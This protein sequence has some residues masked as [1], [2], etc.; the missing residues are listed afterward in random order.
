MREPRAG[1][2]AEDQRGVPR[3][4]GPAFD[5]GAFEYQY[6]PFF[7]AVPSL[8]AT[9]VSL[10]IA[11]LLPDRIYTL[12]VSTNLVD[13]VDCK[14]FGTCSNTCVLLESNPGTPRAHF[15]RVKMSLP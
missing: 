10:E 8:A 4:Q 11:G 9:N 5:I 7:K 6:V 14:S 1:A 15:Y 12:Q 13:W 2:P 3:P